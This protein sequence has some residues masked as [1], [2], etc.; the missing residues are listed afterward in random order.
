M[1]RIKRFKNIFL[2][3]MVLIFSS[4]LG[5]LSKIAANEPFLSVKFILYYCIILVGLFI[6][7]LVWQQ[8]LKKLPLVTAY[9][10]KA[11]T[12]IWGIIWGYLFFSEA[13]TANKI[14]GAGIII[15]GVYFVVS[16]DYD[17]ENMGND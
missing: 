1:N 14:I 12:I 13:I 10:N 15:I 17:L 3:H 8:L 9:A 7:A 5:I 2:L 4:L 6:Y 16:A 11:V